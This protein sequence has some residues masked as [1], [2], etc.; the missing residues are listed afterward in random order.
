MRRFIARDSIMYYAI[1]RICDR[2]SGRLD[3]WTD[4]RPSH[5]WI[6]QKRLKLGS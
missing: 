4:G 2:N 3:V 6:V 5:G 1:V